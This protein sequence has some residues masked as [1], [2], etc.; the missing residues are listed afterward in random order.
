MPPQNPPEEMPAADEPARRLVLRGR[1]EQASAEPAPFADGSGPEAVRTAIREIMPGMRDCYEQGLAM[2]PALAGRLVLELTIE[3]RE[4]VGRIIDASIV[5]EA[6]T[7]QA[8]LVQACVLDQL[9]GATFPA[10]R[11]H[12]AIA[13]RY[14]F[15]FAA[16]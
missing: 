12:G 1:Q 14:P 4:G 6:T 7:L 5:E 2:D 9:S 16:R 10:P 11:D 13:V 3:A 15:E 8:V